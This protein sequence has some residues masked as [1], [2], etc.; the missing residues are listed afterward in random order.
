MRKQF[1]L[2]LQ[3]ELLQSLLAS[4]MVSWAGNR[5]RRLLGRLGFEHAVALEEDVLFVVFM[6]LAPSRNSRDIFDCD[7]HTL[8]L[9]RENSFKLHQLIFY[10]LL[11]LL[12]LF[13]HLSRSVL[14]QLLWT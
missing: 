8:F 4:L 10:R 9:R 6:A 11:G 13:E 1:V 7:Q 5:H 14:D 2:S 3:A 12:V